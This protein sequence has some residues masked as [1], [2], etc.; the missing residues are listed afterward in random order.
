M[1]INVKRWM[2]MNTVINLPVSIMISVT[3]SLLHGG[4][5]ITTLWFAVLG[6]LLACIVNIIIP[7][8]RV[9]IGFAKYFKAN[10]DSLIEKLLGNIAGTFI[11]TTIVVLIMVI[12][13]VG[14]VFPNFIFAF[15]NIFPALYL[16]A[17]IVSFVMAPI[18]IKIAK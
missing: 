10:P 3:A 7:I 5:N 17:Y 14:F 11:V 9:N 1:K 6:Y 2:I 4:I 13:S 8:H 12:I 16:V 18:A 15:L